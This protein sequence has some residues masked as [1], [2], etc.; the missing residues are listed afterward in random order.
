MTRSLNMRELKPGGINF[1]PEVKEI[2]RSQGDK[3]P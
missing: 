1:K 2:G 3:S